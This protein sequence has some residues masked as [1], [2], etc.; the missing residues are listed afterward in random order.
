MGMGSRLGERSALPRAMERKITCPREV[1]QVL[2]TTKF[3]PHRSGVLGA[4]VAAHQRV[5]ANDEYVQKHLQTI[6]E[7][8]HFGCRRMGP[9]HGDLR[10]AEAV[11]PRQIKQLWVEPEALDSLLLENDVTRLPAEGFEAALGVHEGQAQGEAHD[12]IKHD[13]RE[14]AKTRLTDEDQAAIHGAGADGDVVVPQ[15][16][17]ELVGFFD[18]SGKVRVGEEHDATL[19]FEHSVA[20]AVALAAVFAVRNHAQARNFTSE[21][22]RG[23]S[24]AIAGAVVHDDYFRLPPGCANV[25][26]NQRER[27]RQARLLVSRRDDDGKLDGGG[28]HRSGDSFQPWA[29]NRG[30]KRQPS[31]ME[32]RNLSLARST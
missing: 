15:G 6:A 3:I 23:G 26:S 29:P 19:G 25:S 24:G 31:S 20:Y 8:I 4:R 18:R 13:A 10:R 14:L 12:G 2:C 28:A 21:R 7:H 11:M 5:P 27:C 30:T 17:Q 22:L 32:V 16:S 1:C 9:A